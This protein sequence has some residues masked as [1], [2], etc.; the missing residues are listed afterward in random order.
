MAIEFG[1]TW[2]VT[3]PWDDLPHE[4]K[5]E[6]HLWVAPGNFSELKLRSHQ[7]NPPSMLSG[8]HQ[9]T[10]ATFIVFQSGHDVPE[11][12]SSP[13]AGVC[14]KPELVGHATVDDQT[15]DVQTDAHAGFTLRFTQPVIVKDWR[16][17]PGSIA[18]PCF[19]TPG[20][21]AVSAWSSPL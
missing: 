13:I 14:W 7:G 10:L 6:D 16:T 18:Q 4:L 12:F 19:T 3:S 11:V 1:V 8:H 9:G 20:W 5:I 15:E 21:L 17:E 2:R